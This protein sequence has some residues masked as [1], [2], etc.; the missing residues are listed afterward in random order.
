MGIFLLQKWLNEEYCSSTFGFIVFTLGRVELCIIIAVL[1]IGY[2]LKLRYSNIIYVLNQIFRYS[3]IMES[4]IQ[5]NHGQLSQNQMRKIRRAEILFSLAAMMSIF[6][7]LAYCACL[8]V[9]MEA[10]HA[11]L[12]EWLE[13]DVSLDRKFAPLFLLFIWA[14]NNAGSV[15]FNATTMGLAH[16]VLTISC[17]SLITPDQVKIICQQTTSLDK[18]AIKNEIRTSGLG[19]LDDMQVVNMYRTQQIINILLNEIYATI[20]FSLHHVF[21]LVIFVGITYTILRV[22]QVLASAGPL[23][24]FGFIC[25]ALIPLL[26]EYFESTELNELTDVSKEFVGKCKGMV[27]RRS[28]LRKF[29]V[30]CPPL[31]IQ[32]GYPFFNVCRETFPQFM[33]QC[34]DFLIGLLAAY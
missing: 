32:M 26:L 6:V 30:S 4:L 27:S 10:T 22:P 2:R 20:L 21:C 12:Q 25:G 1:T 11:L 8:C 28:M 15:I 3:N 33:S 13:I 24:L 5:E 18:R 29:S 19:L 16:M 14:V 23:T 9:P 7:P 17:I 34:I 31:R